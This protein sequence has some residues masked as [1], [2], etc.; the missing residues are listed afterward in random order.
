MLEVY[1]L[2]E[3]FCEVIILIL[4]YI[5]KQRDCP[6]DINKAASLLYLQLQDVET[7]HSLGSFEISL[8]SVTVRNLT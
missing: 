2:L 5:Q 6:N 3:P 4:P 1:D 7:C 8:G